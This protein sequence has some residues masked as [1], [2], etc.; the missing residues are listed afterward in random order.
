V[1][2][3][4]SD[5]FKQQ[6]RIP[7][8]RLKNWDYSSPG[9]YFVTI[10]TREKYPYFGEIKNGE[11]V[12]SEI[13]VIAQNCWLEIPNHY[14]FVTLDEFIIM[15][16]H[17]HGILIIN[18]HYVETGHGLSLPE[19]RANQF[20]PQRNNVGIIIGNF[21]SSV[22]RICNQKGLYFFWQTRY[23]DHIIRNEQSLNQI[24]FYIQTNVVNWADDEENHV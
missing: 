9:Y 21:K 11:M 22:K 3:D 7:T 19:H 10:C 13:G 23:Y 8:T 4:F 15:P 6:F 18:T 16:N 24:R 14:P 12:L 17:M 20:G 1:P 5:L 2:I